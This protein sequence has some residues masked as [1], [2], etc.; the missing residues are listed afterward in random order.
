MF[1]APNRQIKPQNKKSGVKFLKNDKND[2]TSP[3]LS[4]NDQKPKNPKVF[5]TQK[6]TFS[7]QNLSANTSPQNRFM[8][9]D[10]PTPD[11]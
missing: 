7:F 1:L 10:S 5:K 11:F 6:V 9:R 2:Q 3:N 4:K 8:N